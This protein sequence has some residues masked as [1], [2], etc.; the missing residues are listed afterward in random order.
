M[1]SG[2]LVRLV[3][4]ASAEAHPAVAEQ[5]QLGHIFGQADGI[6][7]RQYTNPGSQTER[8]GTLGDSRKNHLGRGKNSVAGLE[9]VFPNP[10]PL[11]TQFLGILSLFEHF[12]IELLVRAQVFVVVP[13]RE[14]RK[15]HGHASF[16]SLSR[17]T[18]ESRGEG[19]LRL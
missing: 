14:N 6:V 2:E 18:R 19:F 10:E 12:V 4:P 9:V 15:A 8:L 16:F 11:V 3:A 7:D 17:N 5:I 1:K 13:Q